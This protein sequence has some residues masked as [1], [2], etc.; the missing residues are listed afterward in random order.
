MFEGPGETGEV[1]VIQFNSSVVA[2]IISFQIISN[3]SYL[4]VNGIKINVG[5]A[6]DDQGGYRNNFASVACHKF[7]FPFL[8]MESQNLYCVR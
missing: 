6:L 3:N 1:H 5:K 4:H 2:E 8:N 7:R